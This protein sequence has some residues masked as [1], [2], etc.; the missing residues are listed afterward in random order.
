MSKKL[1]KN[2]QKRSRDTLMKVEEHGRPKT[3]G[4]NTRMSSEAALINQQRSA[5]LGK[6][7]G[8][9]KSDM[10][11][12]LKSL[13]DSALSA[14]EGINEEEGMSSNVETKFR[15]SIDAIEETDK[16]AVVIVEDDEAIEPVKALPLAS[17]H[18]RTVESTVRNA[19]Q[20]DPK[21][22]ETAPISARAIYAND[23]H[24]ATNLQAH[25]QQKFKIKLL[26]PVKSQMAL[27][28][29]KGAGIEEE[30]SAA[31]GERKSL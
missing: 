5:S 31:Q 2:S 4:R 30:K 27:R 15:P 1:D 14:D 17:L 6:S 12:T 28:E 21:L 25:L 23:A 3:A 29:E 7:A 16:A 10:A 11:G 24:S 8:R 26:Q 9:Q 19:D 13:D 22:N 20:K 18:E